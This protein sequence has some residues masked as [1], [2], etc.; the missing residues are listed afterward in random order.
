MD[1]IFQGTPE[2]M[3]ITISKGYSPSRRTDLEELMYTMI[4]LLKKTLPWSNTKGK[5]HADNAEK[6]AIKKTIGFDKLFKDLPDELKFMYKNIIKL[7]YEEKPDYPLYIL[8]LKTILKNINVEV[9]DNYEFPFYRKYISFIQ[10][11]K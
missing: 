6:W 8:L 1:N 2:F 11:K 9:D 10:N 4:F 3:A 7:E 5:F